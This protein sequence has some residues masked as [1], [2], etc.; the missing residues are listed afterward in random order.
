M[1]IKCSNGSKHTHQT[2]AESRAC[3]GASLQI[4]DDRMEVFAANVAEDVTP[5]AILVPASTLAEINDEQKTWPWSYRKGKD[6][7][8]FDMGRRYAET[9]A[10]L[11]VPVREWDQPLEDR[12]TVAAHAPAEV[13]AEFQEPDAQPDYDTRWEEGR[14]KPKA[15]RS[16]GA[17]E[18]MRKF[19]AVLL[20][21]R[22]WSRS[23]DPQSQN[24]ETISDLGNG[25]WIS[26]ASAKLLIETLK[27]LPKHGAKTEADEPKPANEQPWRKL[28]REVPAGNYKVTA[29]DGK[30]H[31]Y[32]VSVGKNGFYKLQE[33]AS[34]ELHFVSLNRYAGILK[35]I[36]EAGVE[37]AHLAYAQDQS[38]CWHC[39]TKLTDNT[40]NPHYGRGLGPYCGEEH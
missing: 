3:W 23:I 34:E 28:S 15:A 8:P 36:L 33:R 20:D 37:A 24:G 4:E 22:D 13:W 5:E 30:N 29:E 12:E 2:V 11:G 10:E 6:K 1:A 35:T 31:F 27:R 40:G 17:T 9:C 25:E 16:G 32:R 14:T 7:H 21:E 19:L 38:R 39:N 18:P 26:F